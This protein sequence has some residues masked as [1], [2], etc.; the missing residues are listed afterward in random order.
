MLLSFSRFSILCLISIPVF[1][2]I[3]WFLFIKY[4][5][6][7]FLTIIIWLTDSSNINRLVRID[8]VSIDRTNIIIFKRVIFKRV[9]IHAHLIYF[10]NYLICT[11]NQLGE[12]L[13]NILS[14]FYRNLPAINVKLI[15]IL[16]K[17]SILRNFSLFIKINLITNNHQYNLVQIQVFVCK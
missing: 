17:R 2:H 11:F 15:L 16:F 9:I 5:F 14:S 13:F 1:H 4:N 12:K 10:Y 7:Y 6:R 8:W 3:N